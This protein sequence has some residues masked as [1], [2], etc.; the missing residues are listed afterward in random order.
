M[1]WWN[2]MQ[3]SLP[4]VE[5]QGKRGIT[6]ERIKMSDHK[7]VVPNNKYHTTDTYWMPKYQR[8]LK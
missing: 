3:D 4:D 6:Y 1:T 7:V 8:P 5:T 2:P